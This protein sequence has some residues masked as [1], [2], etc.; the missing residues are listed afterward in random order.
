MRP[1]RLNT[2][3]VIYFSMFLFSVGTKTYS[4]LDGDCTESEVAYL[5]AIS[6]KVDE[7]YLHHQYTT[8][9]HSYNTRSLSANKFYN[10]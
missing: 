1:L 10:Y 8:R 6:E 3:A 7:R 9:I 5:L 4:F 2:W